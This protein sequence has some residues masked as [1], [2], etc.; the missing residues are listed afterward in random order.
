MRNRFLMTSAA[1]VLG[2]SL[3]GAACSDDE[4]ADETTTTAAAE[5]T[6]TTE[7]ETA[8]E[9]QTVVE[10]AQ[11]NPDFSTLVDLVVQAELAE[12]LSGEGPFTVMAPTNDAF[13]AVDEATLSALTADPTGALTDVLTLHVIA[14]EVDAAAA[15]AAAGTCVETLGGQVKV[16]AT[17]DGGLT[18][19]GANIVSTDIVGSNGIIHV[20][21]AVVTA[22]S[23]DC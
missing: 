19:G 2:L 4:T 9:D 6:T 14:G 21:D 13:A 5:E 1:L 12:T 3:I 16:E 22:A 11:S 10:I 23:T 18:F 17:D 15:T 8:T 7:A 20:L